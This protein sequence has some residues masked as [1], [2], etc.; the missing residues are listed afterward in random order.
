MSSKA[1]AEKFSQYRLMSRVSEAR[2]LC[3]PVGFQ[4]FCRH[5]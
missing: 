2:Y 5:I 4:Q 3:V 1:S